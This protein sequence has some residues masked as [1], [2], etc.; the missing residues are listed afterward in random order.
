M[1]KLAI[2]TGASSGIGLELAKL[3]AQDGY[4]LVVAADTPL[5]DASRAL[6][7]LGGP[8]TNVETDLPPLRASKSCSTP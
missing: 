6:E 3:A 7:R 4:E 1:G 8:I 2:V 5:V